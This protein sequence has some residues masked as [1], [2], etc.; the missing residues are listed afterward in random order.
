MDLC[1]LGADPIKYVDYCGRI[2]KEYNIIPDIIYKPGRAKVLKHF[3]E[4]E[5]IFKTKHFFQLY[6]EQARLNIGAE[7]KRVTS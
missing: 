2:R 6:E 1:I 3:L 7:L 4:M 5:R